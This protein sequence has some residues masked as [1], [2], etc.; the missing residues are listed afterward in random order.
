MDELVWLHLSD[1]HFR[2]S[3][4]WQNATV[5]DALL[6]FLA[7]ELEKL[8]IQVDLIFCT[9]DIAFGE[10]TNQPLEAQYELA[11]S[12]FDQVLKVC[13]CDKTHLFLVPGNHDIDRNCV[14]KAIQTSW[15]LWGDDTYAN[16]MA[17]EIP[18][19]F[20]KLAPDAVDAMRRLGKWGH[21]IA[22]YAPHHKL[23]ALGHH[24][25]AQV[26]NIRGRKIGIAGFNSVWTCSGSEDDRHLWLAATQQFNH[27]RSALKDADLKVG[28]I[29]H[30]SDWFNIVE[31]DIIDERIGDEAHF[32]L[33]G[34][35]HKTW[36]RPLPSHVILGAGAITAGSEAE[37]G[38]NIVKLD[39][40]NGSGV[41]R[42]YRYQKS[43]AR[44][45]SANHI[46]PDGREIWEFDLPKELL[47]LLKKPPHDKETI[48][49][50]DLPN[51]TSASERELYHGLAVARATSDYPRMISFLHQILGI[52]EKNFDVAE[53]FG[54]MSELAW[55]TW[56]GG[57]LSAARKLYRQLAEEAVR[58][59]NDFPDGEAVAT[60][61]YRRAIG[62]D[63]ELMEPR[64]FLINT[65]AVLKRQQTLVTFNSIL[66]RLVLFCARFGFPEFGYKFAQ[67]AFN[68]IG[69]G[70]R[71]NE[72]TVLC[73]EL[74]ALYTPSSPSIALELFNEALT[75]T[76]DDPERACNILQTFINDSLYQ[77]N[78]L[79]NASFN[80]L[81]DICRDR[82]YSE[83]LTRATLLRASLSLR[84]G[85]L[86]D[87]DSWL[88]QAITKVKLHKLKQFELA[89]INDQ[90]LYCLLLENFE[91]AKKYFSKLQEEFERITSELIG[92]SPLVDQVYQVLCEA[93]TKIPHEPLLSS[94]SL[95]N[96][97]PAYCD[98]MGEMQWNL[99]AFASILG[100]GVS[101][102]YS[103]ELNSHKWHKV[104]EFRRIEI[105]GHPLILGSY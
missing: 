75:L 96:T 19:W 2:P 26:L 34:H 76:E 85:N 73:S 30:P 92:I 60:D 101:S 70:K 63:L 54:Y 4:E 46:T 52:E 105:Q 68:Y 72:G 49:N 81:C 53:R 41:T 38:F 39:F 80:D 21:F 65:I 35:V 1:I 17:E 55:A 11:S 58:S 28:L 69:D 33:H 18:E 78:K 14:T 66:N 8:C 47:R 93:S 51:E 40:E 7:K 23:A 61:A 95:P 74:G 97:P 84:D 94:I 20:A 88:K 24:H 12:F 57:S 56:G 103:L 10:L 5:R 48:S 59:T 102:K 64:S 25:Y 32:W 98:P 50:P 37:F 104:N 100:I 31:R 9:G 44:W 90:I 27:M 15:T 82:G 36:M 13:G 67:I 42:P 99:S 91:N 29:H 79:D 87:A 43:R 77:G 62:I 6:G 86:K 3:D 16:K 45:I 89:V 22:N 83:T 71:E